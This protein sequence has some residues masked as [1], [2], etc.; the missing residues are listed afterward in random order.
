MKSP[1]VKR[2]IVI[3]GH[4]TSVSLEDAFWAGLKEI[5][6]GKDMTLSEMVASIDGG[7]GDGNLSSAIRLFVL[8]YYRDAARAARGI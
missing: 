6:H 5:A 1:V 4:K 3:A 2:S 8:D 7:R